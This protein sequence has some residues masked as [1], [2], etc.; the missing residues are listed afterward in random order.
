MKEQKEIIEFTF[1]WINPNRPKKIV[2][3]IVFITLIFILLE[4]AEQIK[5]LL[6]LL[7]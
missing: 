5:S 7:F 2:S 4:H 6:A 1:K 3:G